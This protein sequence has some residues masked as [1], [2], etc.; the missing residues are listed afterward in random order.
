LSKEFT[1]RVERDTVIFENSEARWVFSQGRPP[2]IDDYQVAITAVDKNINIPVM[3]IM[4]GRE[5]RKLL[6]DMGIKVHF[7]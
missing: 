4:S 2:H 6:I 7:P 3:M 1:K 5:F